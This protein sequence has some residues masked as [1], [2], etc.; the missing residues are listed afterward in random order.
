MNRRVFAYVDT[1]VADGIQLDTQG[2][3]YSGTGDGV[4]VRIEVWACARYGRS[5][6]AFR[7]GTLQ[8]HS[9]ANSSWRP[10]QQI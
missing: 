3:V 8:E 6:T 1:G 7:Y 10:R 2:N 5:L 9:W 4:Q